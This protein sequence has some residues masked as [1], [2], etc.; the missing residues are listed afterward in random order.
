LTYIVFDK[1][2]SCLELERPGCLTCMTSPHTSI[3]Y[4]KEDYGRYSPTKSYHNHNMKFKQVSTHGDSD[5][6]DEVLM[7]RC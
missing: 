7:R 6:Y 2:V 4:W 5:D 1:L 3:E